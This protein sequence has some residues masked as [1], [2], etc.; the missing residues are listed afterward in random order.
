[1]R[2]FLKHHKK[3][4]FVFFQNQFCFEDKENLVGHLPIE[5]SNFLNNFLTTGGGHKQFNCRSNT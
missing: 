1:M 4:T 5:L 2:C 3:R